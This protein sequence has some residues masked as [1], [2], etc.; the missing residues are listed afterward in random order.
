MLLARM[1]APAL[2]PVHVP[3]TSGLLH[4][5]KTTTLIRKL[6]STSDSIPGSPPTLSC[7]STLG[8]SSSL[9]LNSASAASS[10][11]P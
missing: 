10:L 6:G 7:F 9:F 2:D 1:P 3:V 11:S 5:R 4:H 8:F